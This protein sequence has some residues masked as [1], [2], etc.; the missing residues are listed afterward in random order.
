MD[1]FS[2]DCRGAELVNYTITDTSGGIHKITTKVSFEN[3]K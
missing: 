2:K 3:K 1:G